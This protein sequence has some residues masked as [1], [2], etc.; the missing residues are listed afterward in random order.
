MRLATAR[1]PPRLPMALKAAHTVYCSNFDLA[2]LDAYTHTAI[3]EHLTHAEWNVKNVY[4]MNSKKSFKIEFTT[5]KEA[6]KF[7]ASKTT[8]IGGIQLP[9]NTK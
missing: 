8:S 3:R 5:T 4:I 2:L 6:R 1:R 9:Q 7:V